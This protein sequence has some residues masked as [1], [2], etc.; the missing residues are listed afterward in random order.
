MKKR[1]IEIVDNDDMIIARE[2][3]NNSY[4]SD[5]WADFDTSVTLYQR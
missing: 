2:T 3:N 5:D 1:K 4:V